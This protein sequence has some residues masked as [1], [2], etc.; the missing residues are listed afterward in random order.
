METNKH[1]MKNPGMLKP[2]ASRLAAASLLLLPLAS[3]PSFAQTTSPEGSSMVRREDVGNAG[4]WGLFGLF[5]LAGLMRR[6]SE[7]T[8]TYAAREGQPG[9]PRR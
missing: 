3:T 6:R 1:D 7:H 9:M 4:L 8:S 5:G 2:V